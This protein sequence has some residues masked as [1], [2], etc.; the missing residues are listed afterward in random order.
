MEDGF[1]GAKSGLA[2][3]LLYLDAQQTDIVGKF[4]AS[5]KRMDFGEGFGSRSPLGPEPSHFPS[6]RSPFLLVVRG[7]KMSCRG[8][9]VSQK[10]I[11][12][13]RMFN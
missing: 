13:T 11:G 9:K 6:Q 3:Q 2:F 10:L 12:C 1:S 7:R 5:G 8:I 4:L